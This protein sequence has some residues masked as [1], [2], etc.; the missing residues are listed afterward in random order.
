M[1]T[2]TLHEIYEHLTELSGRF[3]DHV[4]TLREEIEEAQWYLAKMGA[5]RSEPVS[6]T[7]AALPSDAPLDANSDSSF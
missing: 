1:N 6:S 5:T 7:D 4:E 2:E 3:K